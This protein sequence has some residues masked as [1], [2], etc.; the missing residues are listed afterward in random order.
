MNWESILASVTPALL[1]LAY[2]LAAQ[3]SAA[4]VAY[5]ADKIATLILSLQAKINENKIMAMV[6]FDDYLFSLLTAAVSATKS[7]LVDMLKRASEDG[8]LTKEEMQM[9][10]DEAY[11]TFKASLTGDQLKHITAVLGGDL[12]KV[13]KARI[14]SVVEAIK[15]S[16]L[17]GSQPPAASGAEGEQS[18]K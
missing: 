18:F 9:C 3:Y 2:L 5:I 13:V 7:K 17:F 10:V 6:A 14:P 12:E 11:A 4:V 1:A 8:K 15:A 16:G